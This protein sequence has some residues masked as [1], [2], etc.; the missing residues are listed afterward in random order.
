VIGVEM[1]MMDNAAEAPQLMLAL[2]TEIHTR[3]GAVTSNLKRLPASPPLGVST[4]A[5]T[6]SVH[7]RNHILTAAS[8][9]AKQRPPRMRGLGREY[10]AGAEIK[11]IGQLWAAK[12]LALVDRS[13]GDRCEPH[14]PGRTQ[15][16][17]RHRHGRHG[18]HARSCRDASQSH[19]AAH[20]MTDHSGASCLHVMLL[21]L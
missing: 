18:S 19:L 11:Q 1:I 10:A 16:R 12:R 3:I 14:Y 13:F 4:F 6:R 2:L 15:N 5:S 21:A 8:G 7:L 9:A 20:G 17:T